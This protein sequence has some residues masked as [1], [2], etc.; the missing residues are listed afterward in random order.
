MEEVE[1]NKIATVIRDVFQNKHDDLV[2]IESR[3][4]LVSHYGT[5]SQDLVGSLS[6]SVEELL[7]S[8]G[9]K[10]IVIKRM[11]SILLEGLQNIRIHG[12]Q[13]DHG[14]QLGFLLIGSD[15]DNYKVV[16]SNIIETG[17]REKMDAYLSEINSYTEEELKEKYLSVLSNEFLSQKG[18]AG[19]GFITTR[20]KSGKFDYSFVE[21]GSDALL[22]SLELTLPR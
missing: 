16:M 1:N 7:I 3:K 13:D 19:L 2:K 17:E 6:N 9:D 22:F 20:I 10:K 12:G 15:D 5:F 4:I 18:G 8:I 11:F 14:N 21:V